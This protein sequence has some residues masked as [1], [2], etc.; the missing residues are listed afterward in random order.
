MLP[1]QQAHPLITAEHWEALIAIH[2][3]FFS[4][5]LDDYYLNLG[6]RRGNHV[7]H[8]LRVLDTLLDIA[9]AEGWIESN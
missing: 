6:V 7:M 3:K 8:A 5:A 4:P 2:Y 9:Q 1:K